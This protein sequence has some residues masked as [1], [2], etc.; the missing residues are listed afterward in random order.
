MTTETIWTDPNGKEWRSLPR[1]WNGTTNITERWALAHGWT[2]ST[3]EVD[4]PVEVHT[5][6]K[7]KLHL[8]L[9]SAGLWDQVWNALDDGQKQLWNDAQVLASD[10]QFFQQVLASMRAMLPG[11]DADAILEQAEEK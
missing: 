3:R 7:Y 4:D 11:V 2:K 10:D 6:S 8:A 9:A 5:Y 1:T